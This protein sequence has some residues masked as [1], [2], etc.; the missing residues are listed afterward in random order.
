[1]LNDYWV[2]ATRRA[3]PE[4]CWNFSFGMIHKL[5]KG[6]EWSIDGYYRIMNNLIEYKEG[7]LFSSNKPWEDQIATGG[8]G[9][10][11][12]AEFYFAKTTGIVTASVAYTL[13]W[14]TRKFLT[15]NEGEAF[16]FKYDRRHNLAAQINCHIG[17]HFDVGAAWVYGSGN[18]FTLPLQK[19]TT[20]SGAVYTDYVTA[21]NQGNNYIDQV[22][23]YT[24][25]NA[26]RL[27]SYQHLDVSFTYHKRVKHIEHSFNLSVYNVYNRFNIFSV[28]TDYRP[29]DDGGRQLVFKKLS[30]FPVLPSISYTLKFAAI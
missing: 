8:K 21:N 16:P 6:Y 23:T 24:K 17:K 14:S 19:Y 2:P 20:Y 7:A 22:T 1:V 9:K 12:G 27:P 11:Y 28:Y 3:M 30:L 10:A 15:L 26:Y 25:R 13:G 5:P 29:A 4:T 18:M